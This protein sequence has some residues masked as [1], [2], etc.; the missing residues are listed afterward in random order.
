VRELD[1]VNVPAT[2]SSPSITADGLELF[3][4]SYRNG[5]AAIFTASRADTSSMFSN[6]TELTSLPMVATGIAAG[7]PEIS[8]D[9]RTLYYWVNVN[10]Q[11]ELYAVTRSCP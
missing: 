11:I 10:P 7:G 3:F 5:P 6:L 1:E 4:D 2:D 8:A 9:G